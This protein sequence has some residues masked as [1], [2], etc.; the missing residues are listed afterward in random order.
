[1]GVTAYSTSSNI[2][3]SSP[4]TSFVGTT[5]MVR[6]NGSMQCLEIL[7]SSNPN[8]YANWVRLDVMPNQGISIGL[9][10][11]AETVIS[12]AKLKMQEEQN[13]KVLM[14]RHPGVK[15]AKEKF[16]IMVALTKQEEDRN[17]SS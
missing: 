10:S 3:V 9:S 12:W 17:G 8:N 11:D 2:V 16:D 14:A 4:S 1:M 6:W 13:L 15:D 5:G 7:D